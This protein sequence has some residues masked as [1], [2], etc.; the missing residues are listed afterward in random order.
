MTTGMH[1]EIESHI[2]PTPGI[3]LQRQTAGKILHQSLVESRTSRSLL[4]TS[5]D[6][7]CRVCLPNYHQI[8]LVILFLGLPSVG[9]LLGL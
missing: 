9:F 8:P 7:G 5:Q 6:Y 1:P 3:R 2:I 4:D